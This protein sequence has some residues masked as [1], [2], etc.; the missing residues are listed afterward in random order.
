MDKRECFGDSSNVGNISACCSAITD[1]TMIKLRRTI[2][3]GFLIYTLLCGLCAIIGSLWGYQTQRTA[4]FDSH[5]LPSGS[6]IKN[7]QKDVV[8]ADLDGDGQPEAVVFYLLGDQAHVSVF[9][10]KGNTYTQFWDQAYD[11]AIGF[12]DPTGVYD[13][14][15]TT[16]PQILAYRAIGA[17][18]P[19]VLEIYEYKN[20]AIGRITGKWADNGQ[21]QTVEITDL[22]G[23]GKLEIIVKTRNYGVNPDIYS[24]DGK[25]YVLSNA[26]FPQYYREQLQALLH[27][28]QSQKALPPSARVTWC[29]QAVQIYFLQRRYS[30]AA[31]LCREV[32]RTIDDPALTQ[33]SLTGQLTVEQRKH[34]LA[35]FIVE[36]TRS[37]AAIYRLLG[38]TDKAAGNVRHAQK[39]YRKGKELEQK[40]ENASRNLGVN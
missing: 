37:K 16:L 40:A 15:R 33:P 36:K 8:L 7:P 18:C 6:K 3:G 23:D 34:I 35:S 24:W 19:G 4:V 9:K 32:L 25:Q 30:A 12:S 26:R 31:Q 10:Q 29:G 17:S 20:G 28:I 2:Q 39:Y 14:N 38:D 13:L 27:S 1:S 21:C 5:L 22:N 11:D